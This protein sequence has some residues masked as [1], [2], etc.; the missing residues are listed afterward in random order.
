M[1]DYTP[2][3]CNLHSEYELAIIQGR[4]LRISWSDQNGRY[5]TGVLKP[6]DLHTRNHEEFLVVENLQ[7]QRLVIRLDLIVKT[8]AIRNSR[9]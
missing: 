7:G 6:C 5:H 4:R 3:D 9:T 1:T 8:D 2:I